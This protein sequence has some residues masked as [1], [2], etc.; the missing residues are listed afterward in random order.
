MKT[1]VKRTKKNSVCAINAIN[2]EAKTFAKD[3][4]LDE[5]IEQYSRNQSFITLN[6]HKKNFQKNPKGR[7]INPEKSEI[8]IVIKYCISQIKRSIKEKLNVNQWRNKQ[9]AITWFRKILTRYIFTLPHQRT[10]Y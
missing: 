4:N 7:L 9:A 8:G 2:T 3:L 1:L 6:D 5:R 10:F